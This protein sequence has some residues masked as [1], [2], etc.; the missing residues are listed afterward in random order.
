MKTTDLD[1]TRTDFS[2]RLTLVLQPSGNVLIECRSFGAFLSS[3]E[4]SV[5]NARCITNRMYGGL[6]YLNLFTEELVAVKRACN[7]LRRDNV[8]SWNDKYAPGKSFALTE[9]YHD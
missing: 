3:Y 8:D 7:A 4:A 2:F 6:N 1:F 9:T 5:L